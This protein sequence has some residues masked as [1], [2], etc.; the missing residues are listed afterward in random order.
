[1]YKYEKST[2]QGEQI[3]EDPLAL[4]RTANSCFRPSLVYAALFFTVSAPDMF[5]QPKM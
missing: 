5:C 3:P 4:C 1:M 2:Q